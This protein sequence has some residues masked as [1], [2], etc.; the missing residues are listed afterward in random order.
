MPGLAFQPQLLPPPPPHTHTGSYDLTQLTPPQPGVS[1]CKNPLANCIVYS[2]IWVY[3]PGILDTGLS[4]CPASGCPWLLRV[5]KSAAQPPPRFYHAA[6]V[7][8]CVSL[9]W[10]AS[11]GMLPPG[12]LTHWTCVSASPPPPRARPPR[13]P[14][15]SDDMYVYGGTNGQGAWLTDLWVYRMVTGEWTEVQSTFQNFNGFPTQQVR[16]GAL[17]TGGSAPL[18]C[19]TSRVRP[20]FASHPPRLQWGPSMTAIGHHLYVEQTGDQGGNGL[21]RWTPALPSGSP[22]GGSSPAPSSSNAAPAGTTAGIVIGILVALANTTLLVLLAIKV[23]GAGVGRGYHAA[24]GYC[25][26][27]ATGMRAISISLCPLAGGRPALWLVLC[28]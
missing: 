17:H 8:E 10:S 12:T 1:V 7:S 2:D 19:H 15:V 20:S 5:P 18:P 26:C 13:P 4:A 22:S 25:F 27:T 6:A 14:A 11:L 28:A 9:A 23:G 3:R 16:G 21:Y 24:Y